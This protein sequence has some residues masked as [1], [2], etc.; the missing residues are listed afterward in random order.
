MLDTFG[1]QTIDCHYVQPQIACAYLVLE[2]GR[3]LFIENN[4]TK[5]VPYLLK[6]LETSQISPEHIEFLIITHVHLDHAGGTSALLTHCPNATVL[7]H[8]KAARHVID[9][10]RLIS[11]AEAVYGKE[12]FRDL[13]G[14]INPVP[15]ERVRI[16]QDNEILTFGGRKLKFIYTKGHA[17]HHF[18]IYDSKSNGIFT[19]DTFGIAYPGLQTGNRSFL[20]P[21]TTP[22]DFDPEEA[23]L[24]LEKIRATGAERAYLTH[25]GEFTD[26]N[27]GYDQMSYGLEEMKVIL[28]E[29]TL[30]GLEGE[31]LQSFCKEKVF[32]FMKVQLANRALNL[33]AEQIELLSLDVELNAMGLAFAALR[34]RKK[35]TT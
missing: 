15:E 19:G 8:P 10:S 30:G 14:E 16:M 24:S 32:N 12:K 7:A 18:C 31:E 28:D 34:R 3:G 13:Y 23:F 27:D 26:M 33:D 1:I 29:A 2:E 6:Q 20:F 5:A 35:I 22:T 9:P 4:T 21:T 25:F 11:S 17:N